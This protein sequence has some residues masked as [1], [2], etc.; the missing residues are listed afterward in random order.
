MWRY[1]CSKEDPIERIDLAHYVEV[2]RTIIEKGAEHRRF[3]KESLLSVEEG[4]K[5]WNE[6]VSAMKELAQKNQSKREKEWRRSNY[7]TW[8]H[9]YLH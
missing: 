6:V 8:Q 4:T 7:F 2:L 3:V 9:E 1:G 5:A